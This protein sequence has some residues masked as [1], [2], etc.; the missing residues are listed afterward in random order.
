M[1]GIPNAR[2]APMPKRIETTCCYCGVG[3]GITIDQDRYGALHLEGTE[4][5]IHRASA[6]SAPRAAP[7]ITPPA[8]AAPASTSHKSATKRAS[9][10]HSSWD[11][12]MAR[13]RGKFADIIAE[14]GPD[15]VAFYGSGQCLTE[16][17]YCI[18]KLAKGFIGTNNFDTNSRLCM[19]SAVVAYKQSLGADA[20]PISYEDLECNDVCLIGG[21]NPAW[22]HPIIFQRLMDH[23]PTPRTPPDCHRPPTHRQRRGGRSSPCGETRHRRCP[24]TWHHPTAHRKRPR[25]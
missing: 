19:S 22:A 10:Q 13:P 1:V 21:A 20:P 6:N 24:P 14:H 15:A 17:Y 25:R 16:E 4:S 8:I 7:F 23:R 5:A 9:F 12:A 3:C 2:I 11:D 18:N